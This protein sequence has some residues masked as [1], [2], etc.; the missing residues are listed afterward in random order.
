MALMSKAK[1]P[2]L[3]GTGLTEDQ[4]ACVDLLEQALDEARAG[5]IGTIGIVVCMDGG[6]ASVMAGRKAGDLHLGCA[7]LMDRIKEATRGKRSA[8]P[9]SKIIKLS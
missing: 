8:A 2:F 3:V 6:Y 5:K 7:D 9:A 4:Q 1:P